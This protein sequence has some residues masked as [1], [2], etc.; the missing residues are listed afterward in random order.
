MSWDI[1]VQDIPASVR[2]VSEMPDDF[3]PQLL[4]KRAEIIA[5]IRE[6]VPTS[7]FTDPTWG[8]IN[9]PDFSIEVSLGD[10]EDVHSFAFHV[11]GGELAAVVVADVLRHL[12][13]RAFD[14][15]SDS[16]IFELDD[17]AAGLRKWRTYRDHIMG[18]RI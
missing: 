12:G 5:R 2:A 6:V 17:A 3:E 15:N 13:F 18:K 9:G 7:D 14:P 11:R 16:G 10:M 4:G 1:F 8:Q